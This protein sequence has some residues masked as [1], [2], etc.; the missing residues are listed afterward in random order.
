MRDKPKGAMKQKKPKI[1]GKSNVKEDSKM[2]K[3][4]KNK[5][6]CL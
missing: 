6:G 3:K 2:V 4:T 1:K 5:D